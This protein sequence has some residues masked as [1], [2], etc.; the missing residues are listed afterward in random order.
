MNKL[1]GDNVIRSSK[2]L[3][4]YQVAVVGIGAYVTVEVLD[5]GTTYQG[6]VMGS[7]TTQDNVEPLQQEL[8]SRLTQGTGYPDT[9]IRTTYTILRVNADGDDLGQPTEQVA[10]RYVREA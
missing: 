10:E 1:F 8:S 6:Y 2:Y 4:G 7:T 3:H 5:D 9:E